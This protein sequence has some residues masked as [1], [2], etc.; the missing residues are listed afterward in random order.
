MQ[1]PAGHLSH[2]TAIQQ[3]HLDAF[4]KIAQEQ[5]YWT[6]ASGAL[7]ASHDDETMLYAR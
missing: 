2:L 7:Q 3:K 5:H 6:P 1:Y 4:K